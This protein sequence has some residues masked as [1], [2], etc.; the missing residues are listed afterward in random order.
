MR[1]RPLLILLLIALPFCGFAQKAYNLERYTGKLNG[2]TITLELADGFIGGSAIKIP[3][4]S[5]Q[6]PVTYYANSGM[7]EANNTMLF[8]SKYLQK[9]D[10]FILE[11]MQEVYKDIPDYI[12]GKYYFNKKAVAVK[13]YRD[14]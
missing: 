7:P 8:Q 5:D 12:N 1:Y 11:N 3:R 10:H 4:R 2:K 14:K 6:S 13:F 9:K